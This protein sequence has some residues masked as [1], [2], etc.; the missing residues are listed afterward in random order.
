MMLGNIQIQDI[1]SLAKSK[2]IPVS[3]LI[4]V[5]YICNERCNHCFLNSHKEKG[6]TLRQYK[7]L[8][9]Q[10]VDAGTMFVILTGGEPFT[11]PDFMDIVREARY[12]KRGKKKAYFC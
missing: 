12:R 7:N 6:L 1:M 3:I 4:E 8:F 5:C 2:I 11:R 10:M 9:A